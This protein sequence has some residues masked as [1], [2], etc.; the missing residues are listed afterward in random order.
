MVILSS[1]Y[2]KTKSKRIKTSLENYIKHLVFERL[3][4]EQDVDL[5]A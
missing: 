1:N 2:K 4:S 5:V 3:K